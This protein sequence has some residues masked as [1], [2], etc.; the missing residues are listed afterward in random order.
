VQAL[1]TDPAVVAQGFDAPDA[2]VGCK[3]DLPQRGQIAERTTDREVVG[4]VDGGFGA[5]RLA[6]FVVLLLSSI[7]SRHARRSEAGPR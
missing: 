1:V 2:S 4:V 7:T 5:E 6:F 3:A